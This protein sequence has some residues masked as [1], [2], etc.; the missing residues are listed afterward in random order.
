MSDLPFVVGNEYTRQDIYEILQVPE[1]KRRG[2]WETGYTRWG[3][4]LF[5][6]PT[7]GS[8]ATGGYDYDNGWEG[9]IFRW[10]AK[11]NTRIDQPQIQ[12]ILNEA[13]RV[14]IF[15]RSAVRKP[16]RFEGLGTP[17]SW[18]SSSPVLIRWQINRDASATDFA[19]LP[20]EEIAPSQYV[21]GAV[22]VVSVNAYERNP[23]ARRACVAHY[24]YV[25]VVC[26][27]DFATI[28]G[29]LGEQFTHVH[30]L[31]DLATIGEEYEVDPIRD[32]RPVCPNCHAMLHR[33]TPAM[34]IEDLKG[35]IR[36]RR[37]SKENAL[38][39]RLSAPEAD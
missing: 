24:G 39:H 30:H 26:G 27:F 14:F 31:R 33:C 8:P 28:Y 22:R 21:E 17:A 1:D 9:E 35:I 18:E 19:I 29:E 3:D 37:K 15:T 4:D 10:Y 34:S 32:L 16:F 25:C 11:E 20:S 6:F 13:K 36:S 2:N 23:K 38:A 7:V 12:W 5:M